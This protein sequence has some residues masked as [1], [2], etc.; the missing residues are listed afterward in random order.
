MAARRRSAFRRRGR[1]GHSGFP[2][3]TGCGGAN[4]A[5]RIARR[6]RFCKAIVCFHPNSANLYSEVRSRPVYTT[7]HLLEPSCYI[8]L[9]EGFS[10]GNRV[11]TRSIRIPPGSSPRGI[12]FDPSW[13]R[14]VAVSGAATHR[15]H[16]RNEFPDPAF[17]I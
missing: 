6:F 9:L 13:I 12:F 7:S 11:S 17:Q 2:A 3:E 1:I 5:R 15:A 14:A 4:A 8:L 10:Y 16:S